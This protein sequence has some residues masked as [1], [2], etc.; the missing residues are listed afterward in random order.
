MFKFFNLA[1]GSKQKINPYISGAYINIESMKRFK[2][3]PQFKRWMFQ[4]EMRIHKYCWK[5]WIKI[6]NSVYDEE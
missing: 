5:H 1:G 3:K 6:M 2:M 4:N